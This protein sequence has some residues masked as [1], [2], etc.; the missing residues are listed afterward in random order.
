MDGSTPHKPARPT[1][2]GRLFF[3]NP[4]PTNIPD[5]VLL[6]TARASMDFNDPNFLAVYDACVA[7]L[8]KV[9]KTEQHI[10]FYTASGHGA[11]EASLVNTLSPG[12]LVLIPETGYFSDSWA[13]MCGTL[14]FEVQM[15]A[16][17]WRRGCDIAAIEAALAA[18]TQHRIK[19]VCAV[20]NETAAG[21]RLPIE[22]IRAAMDR[23]NH[24]ALLMA[25]TISSLGSYDFRMDEWGVDVCVGG[26]QKGLMLPTGFSFNGA[27]EKALA[28]HRA[29]THPRHYFDWTEML[30]RRHKSFVGTVPITLFYG[31]QESLRLML[32]EEGLENVF[33]RHARLAAGVR[34]AVQHWSGNN[35]PQ[36][37]CQNP[38]R[39]SDSVTA[40]LMP[41]GHNADDLRRV[42][43]E[44]FNVSLGGG[45]GKLGGRVFRIGHLG[46]LNEPMVIGALG[47]V[48]MAMEIAGVPHAKGGVQVALEVYA[49]SA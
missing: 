15:V 39:W 34:A 29:S 12:D 13:K 24:P 28:A 35:G 33:A 7:G 45:L 9:L 41:E 18:D 47:A 37:F 1:A 26:S 8:K 6:A 46:D 5:S 4:G 48:E 14:G 49:K 3:A 19:A 16:A 20:H 11:W 2:R 17:D 31:L 25:D 10:F 44:R 40:I 36:L 42:A 38:E 43:L 22:Q 27:S 21:T 23:V 30:G 32:E